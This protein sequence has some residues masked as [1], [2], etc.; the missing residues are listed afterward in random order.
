MTLLELTKKHGHSREVGLIEAISVAAPELAIFPSRVIKG[1]SFKALVRTSLPATGFTHANEGIPAS[2]SGYATKIVECFIFRGAVNVDKAIADADE[3]GP[4]MFQAVE[5][6]GVGRSA[7]IELGKQIF[8]GTAEDAKGFPGIREQVGSTMIVDATGSTANEASSVYAVKYGPQYAQLIYGSSQ[9]LSLPPFRIQ[10]ITD[11][12]GGQYD[13]YVSN[14]TAWVGLQLVN[15]DALGRIKNLT[16]QAGK[17]LTDALLADL[18]HKFPVGMRP[19]AFFLSRRS[20]SQL[21]KSRAVVLQGNGRGDI[22]SV[23]GTVAPV[24]T[25]AFGVPIIVT[26]S[27]SDKEA[28]A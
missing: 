19:D 2:T 3:D 9:T 27:I 25:E 21:Q 18:L 16:A 8:Y 10:S 6:S 17:G 28:I 12:N 14:L 4:S 5:A 22:G 13:A 26:D 7:A 24:P 11:A 15:G 23:S 1:T 20:L